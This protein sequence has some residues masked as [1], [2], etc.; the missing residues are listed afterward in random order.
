MMRRQACSGTGISCAADSHRHG[1]VAWVCQSTGRWHR[2]CHGSIHR[3]MPSP[4]ATQDLLAVRLMQHGTLTQVLHLL[5]QH[6]G[7]LLQ[8]LERSLRVFGPC[9]G[10]SERLP[11]LLRPRLRCLR[12]LPA[13]LLR[14]CFRDACLVEGLG[15]EPA[16]KS[17]ALALPSRQRAHNCAHAVGSDNYIRHITCVLMYYLHAQCACASEPTACPKL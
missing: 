9:E 2:S 1:M 16:R 10:S 17:C 6:G 15:F 13:H 5:L 3:P 8:P 11:E 12:N 7:L 4:P 14:L